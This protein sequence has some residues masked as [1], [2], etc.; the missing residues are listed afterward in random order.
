MKIAV[1]GGGTGGL[2]TAMVMCSRSPENLKIDLIHDPNSPIIGVG[3]SLSH[4]FVQLLRGA[5]QFQFPF[6]MKEVNATIKHGV[7]LVDWCESQNFPESLNG[8]LSLSCQGVHADTYSWRSFV[9]PRLKHYWG[10]KFKEVHGT[11]DRF[12]QDSKRAYLSMNGETHEYHHIIDCRGIPQ[13]FDDTYESPES[14]VIN[15]AI[16]NVCDKPGDWEWTYHIA[17]PNGWMF[18]IPVSNRSSW[19]YLYNNK[20]TTKEEAIEDSHR[21]LREHRIPRQ[22][23]DYDKLRDNVKSFSW[24]HYHSKKFVDGRILRNGN[25]LYTYEPLHGYGVP[26][27]TTLATLAVEY[28]TYDMSEDELNNQYTTYLSS[29]RDFIAFHYHRGS[30][31]KTPFWDWASEVSLNQVQGSEFMKICMSKDF[32]LEGAVQMDDPWTTS[33]IA[34]PMFIW[35]LDAVFD[36]GYFEHLPELA[37]VCTSC[38]K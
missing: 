32:T 22:H 38:V 23:I 37:H 14:I 13:E 2:V 21:F 9:L 7:A 24:P 1:I 35:E 36:F 20:V 11:V 33:P 30:I 16:I 5:L 34:H 10:H 19:G 27:Y 18:G 29:F 31:H 3:E 15:S 25:A 8:Y 4:D 6:D 26:L 12:W 17:H 28:F